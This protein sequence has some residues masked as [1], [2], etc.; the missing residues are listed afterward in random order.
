MFFAANTYFLP[1][2][3]AAQASATTQPMNV[4]PRR[5]FTIA[6]EFWLGCFLI[7]AAKLGIR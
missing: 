3:L 1:V 7:A 4:H 6:M 5:M 2:G